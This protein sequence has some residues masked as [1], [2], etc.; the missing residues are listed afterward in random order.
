ALETSQKRVEQRNFEIRKNLLKFDD[1]I[2]DQRKAIFEQ[3]IEFMR[4]ANVEDTINDMRHQVIE[5]MCLRHMPEKAYVEHWNLKD[6]EEEVGETL[7][8]VLPVNE[9]AHEEGV[10]PLEVA[11]KI[12]AATDD[13]YRRKAAAVGEER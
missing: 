9:W 3:R 8:L 13:F 11:E 4:A 10:A 7:G 1:V 5:D 2:N 6:L 12:I